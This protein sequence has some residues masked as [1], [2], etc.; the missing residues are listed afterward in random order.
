[1]ATGLPINKKL[2]A[3][4]NAEYKLQ[5]SCCEYLN[6]YED[7]YYISDTVA[8]VKLTAQQA[9]RNSKIQKKGFA[10]S[11]III[12]EPRNG[13][14]GLFVELK[15]ES[16]YLA[17]NPQK[18]KSQMISNKKNPNLSYDHLQRQN[19]SMKKMAAKGYKCYFCW[20]LLG[21]EELF[22]NYLNGT[23]TNNR[24]NTYREVK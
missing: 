23:N 14:C 11:D 8:S 18:L 20:D 22:K 13:Y 5:V 24:S 17:S 19:D 21:F 7:I 2:P 15:K 1:M 10:T 3:I 4:P 9:V 12:F 6:W 16:P